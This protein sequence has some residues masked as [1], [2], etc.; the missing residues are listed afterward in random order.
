M[1]GVTTMRKS[2]K[3]IGVTPFHTREKRVTRKSKRE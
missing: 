1:R 2:H 3:R